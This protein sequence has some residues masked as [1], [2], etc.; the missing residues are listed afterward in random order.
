MHKRAMSTQKLVLRIRKYTHDAAPPVLRYVIRAYRFPAPMW[1]I[2]AVPLPVRQK[3]GKT[4]TP[5][6]VTQVPRALDREV[7][8]NND[9]KLFN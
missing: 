3:R 9:H 8:Y 5:A 2:T 7:M 4:L 1:G 6:A